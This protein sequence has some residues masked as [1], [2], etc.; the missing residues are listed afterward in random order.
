MI[1]VLGIQA[2]LFNNNKKEEEER[3]KKETLE[4]ILFSEHIFLNTEIPSWALLQES[5]PPTLRGLE[6]VQMARSI[7]P[8]MQPLHLL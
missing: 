1:Q 8:H 7:P 5:C 6:G 4:A 2:Y 3:E